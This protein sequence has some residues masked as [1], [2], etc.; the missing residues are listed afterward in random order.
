ML[1]TSVK[2]DLFKL[3]G[4]RVIISN[5]EPINCEVKDIVSG[6][7]YYEAM[8]KVYTIPVEIFEKHYREE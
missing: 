6:M 4:R 3:I 8:G 7:V 2:K 1:G 5:P